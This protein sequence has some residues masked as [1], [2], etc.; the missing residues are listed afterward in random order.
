MSS[1]YRQSNQQPPPPPKKKLKPWQI[2]LI[3]IGSILFVGI[4]ILIIVLLTRKSKSTPA[5][6]GPCT[7]ASD[8]P[9]GWFCVNGKCAECQVNS[10]C[11]GTAT[12]KFCDTTHGV[13]VVCIS[14]TDCP[15]ATPHCRGNASCVQ[16]V[17]NAN[18]PTGQ[19]CN[20]SGT[21]ITL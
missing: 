5:P 8:C 18:C 9:P 12:R 3:V 21:C 13:C 14:D 15:T 10:D 6:S 11:S 7:S 19:V 2:A 4:I 17:T 16:C 1:R 20:S